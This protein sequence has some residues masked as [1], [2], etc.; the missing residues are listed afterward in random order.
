[1]P[2]TLASQLKSN[3]GEVSNAAE[4]QVGNSSRTV[5]AFLTALNGFAV[6]DVLV[7]DN[8]GNLHAFLI[9]PAN[10]KVLY[11]AIQMKMTPGVIT[12]AGTNMTSAI[13]GGD[14]PK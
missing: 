10:G 12:T 1:M 14:R 13:M 6:Y 7:V 2:N 9:D 8:G 11:H 4:Q 3:I 5:S